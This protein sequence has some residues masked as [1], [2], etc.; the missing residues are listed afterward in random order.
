[1]LRSTLARWLISAGYSVELAEGERRARE[2]LAHHQIALTILARGRSGA[3]AFTLD[4]SCGKRIVVTEPSQETARPDGSAPPADGPLSIPLDEQAVLA[5]VQSALQAEPGLPDRHLPEP[6]VMSFD[7]FTIDLAGRSLRDGCG[8]EVSMTRSEF[9]L[10]VAFVRNS[11]RVLSRDQLLDA[12]VGRRAEPYDRSIDV[13]VGRLGKKI[14]PDPRTP[15]FV[16]TVVGE[17]YKFAAKVREAAP[18]APE[19]SPALPDKPSIAV[20]PFANLTGDPEQEYFI[21]GVVEEI[22]TALSRIRWLFVIS[23]N[24]NLTYGRRAVDVKQVGRQLGVGYVLEGSVRKVGTRVRIA[25]QLIDATSGAHVWADRFDGSLEDVF[26]LQDNVVVSGAGVIEPALQ[27]AE[28]ARSICRPTNDLSAYDCY[29]RALAVFHPMT[30]EA[31]LEALGLLEQAIAVDRHYGPALALAAGCHMRFVNYSWAEDPQTARRKAVD[32]ARRA[33]QVARDDPGVIASAAMILAVFGEDIGTMTA[34]T[35]YALELNPSCARGWYY[36]GFLRLMDGN[37]N[38]AIELAEI[39]LRL[40]PRTRSGPVHTLIGASHFLSRRFN[41]A[42]PKLLLALEETPNFPVACRYL[43]AC[44]GRMGRLDEARD[45]VKRLRA[46]TPA[47]MPPDIM[48]LRNARH[49]E[50]YLS[51]LR[52]AAGEAA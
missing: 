34:L 20:L 42:I 9:A 24:S 37:P 41:E 27:T 4:R 16:L 14:E 32:L 7:G 47:V 49:R 5:G 33:L 51:G 31:I 3:P 23:R 50:L 21:D 30:K 39:S 48:Y 40:S 43:A 28:A 17:G 19:P 52:L 29:M 44:Y 46:V 22:I 8:S 11:G 36:S 35:D 1:M 12:V 15:S 25:A 45:V 13:L 38:R 6:E 26:A 18:A 10:L 2:V